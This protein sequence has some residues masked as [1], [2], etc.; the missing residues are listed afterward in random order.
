MTNFEKYHDLLIE[1]LNM[2]DVHGIA[3]VDNQ[4]V[5]CFGQCYNCALR[6]SE[7]DCLDAL[8]NWSDEY[9]D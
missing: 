7:N 1:I 4:P 8:I 6:S 2:R 9:I 5:A 3:I